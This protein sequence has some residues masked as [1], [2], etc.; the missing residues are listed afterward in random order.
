MNFTEY[1]VYIIGSGN[2][3]WSLVRS[4]SSASLPVKGIWSRNHEAGMEISDTFHIPFIEDKILFG[5]EGIFILAISDSAIQSMAKQINKNSVVIHTSGT[6]SI[7]IFTHKNAGVFYPLQTFSKYKSVNFSEISIL[8]EYSNN[9]VKNLLKFWAKK[10][11]TQSYICNSE[12][13]M[14]Y[15]IA[16]IFACNFVNHMIAQSEKWL[17]IHHLDFNLLKPLMIETIQKALMQGA[18]SS[19]TGPAIRKDKITIEKHL[20]ALESN[21][22]LKKLYSFVTKSI[23]DFHTKNQENEL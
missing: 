12:D 7:E 3:A 1:P 21:P 9:N 14:N 4:F 19:Q 20:K 22:D 8:I 5:R 2:I 15:H 23:F 11:N 18:F 6:T 17:K 10:L 13:R 16:A